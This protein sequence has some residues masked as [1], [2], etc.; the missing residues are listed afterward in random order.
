MPTANTFPGANKE[1]VKGF[2]E[3]NLGGLAMPPSKK[4]LIVTCMDARIDPAASLG[5]KEGDA[6]VI[7]N[8]GGSARDALR[9]ILVSHH[10]LGTT[11]IAVFHHTG[12]GMLTFTSE[13]FQSQLKAKHPE[14]AK[15][16]ESIDFLTFPALEPS[17]QADVE[18]LRQHP[19]L[20][21]FVHVTGWVHE[22]ET[23]KV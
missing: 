11:E 6:H 3:R 19:L 10:L 20:V 15:E 18:Y 17:V 23:G 7:R 13:E 2:N 16:I 4:L 5:L 21:D 12:C 8:A 22:V 9:S 1:Y 14:Q